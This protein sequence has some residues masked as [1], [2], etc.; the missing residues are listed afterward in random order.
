MGKNKK[1]LYSATMVVCDRIVKK[2]KSDSQ[3]IESLQILNEMCLINGT[4]VLFDN[5][6]QCNPVR[7]CSVLGYKEIEEDW[8]MFGSPIREIDYGNVIRWWPSSIFTSTEGQIRVEFPTF[9]L[10]LNIL[11]ESEVSSRFFEDINIRI[12]NNEDLKEDPKGEETMSDERVYGSVS[13]ENEAVETT[14]TE[15]KR[16]FKLPKKSWVKIGIAAAAVAAAVVATVVL[17]K[18]KNENGSEAGSEATGSE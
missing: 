4:K 9:E 12:D 15:T 8:T 11:H 14:T 1:P 7:I 16:K 6:A 18:K 17:L 10:M 5:T 2:F 13:E 3:T